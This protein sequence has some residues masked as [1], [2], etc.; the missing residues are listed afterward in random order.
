M[1]NLEVNA[2][3]PFDLNNPHIKAFTVD[4]FSNTIYAITINPS[5]IIHK[6]DPSNPS[7]FIV[8]NLFNFRVMKKF[9]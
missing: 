1:Y 3:F 7:I 4:E 8:C 6:Y 5:L 9:H 2:E